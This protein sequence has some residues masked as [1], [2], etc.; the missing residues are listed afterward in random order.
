VV[1][2]IVAPRKT[3]ACTRSVTLLVVTEVRSI[4]VAVHPMV[5]AL[6]AKKARSG[7][8]LDIVALLPPASEGFDV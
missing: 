6:V 1:E 3:M 5:L 4:P 2:G 7:R 8:E